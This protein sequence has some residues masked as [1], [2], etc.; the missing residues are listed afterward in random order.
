MGEAESTFACLYIQTA[1]ISGAH[2]QLVVMG[3]GYRANES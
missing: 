3:T 2:E 1:L